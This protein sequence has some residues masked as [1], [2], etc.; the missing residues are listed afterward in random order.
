MKKK[1][2]DNIVVITLI[3]LTL[4]FTLCFQA[5]GMKEYSRYST[6]TLHYERGKVVEVSEQEI[7]YDEGLGIYLGKQILQV[8]MLEGEEKGE[9]IEVTNYL[10]NNPNLTALSIFPNSGG[11]LSEIFMN[12]CLFEEEHTPDDFNNKYEQCA[13]DIVIAHF[14]SKK[15]KPSIKEYKKIHH[16]LFKED[17]PLFESLQ[18]EH[19]YYYYEEKHWEWKMEKYFGSQYNL[20]LEEYSIKCFSNE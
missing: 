19:E 9:V 12:C 1:V 10:T 3:S 14:S 2:R 7:E 5:F 8:E 17:P 20:K 16:N 11:E 18:E 4:I 15:Q 6:D 13:F